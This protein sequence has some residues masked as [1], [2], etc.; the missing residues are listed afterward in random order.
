MAV[1]ARRMTQ[2][3]IKEAMRASRRIVW[4]SR[5]PVR[6]RVKSTTDGLGSYYHVVCGDE[7]TP[8]F[9]ATC[10]E[11]GHQVDRCWAV[12]KVEAALPGLVAAM[13]ATE[14]KVEPEPK[15]VREPRKH[16]PMS[17]AEV[18]R[19]RQRMTVVQGGQENR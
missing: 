10:R 15:P 3:E 2:S 7:E 5:Y 11:R 18:A 4:D 19:E 9:C 13:K 6:A 12:K 1:A 8:L 17:W 16:Q 14:P